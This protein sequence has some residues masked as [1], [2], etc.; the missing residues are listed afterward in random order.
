MRLNI[1]FI[2]AAIYLVLVTIGAFLAPLA[3][4]MF[5]EI[6]AQTHFVLMAAGVSWLSLGVIAWL[7]RNAEASKTRDSVV[8]GYTALFVLWAV[9]SLYGQLAIPELAEQNSWLQ[10]LIQ[11]LIAVGFIVAGRSRSTQSAI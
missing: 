5:G 9:L 11:G 3:P 4:A 2:I 7:V 10:A 8:L 1:M 6:D